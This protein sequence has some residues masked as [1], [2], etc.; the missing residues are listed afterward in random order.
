MVFIL[1]LCVA[2]VS[3]FGQGHIMESIEANPPD[4]LLF[5]TTFND[6]SARDWSDGGNNGTITT[7]TFSPGAHGGAFEFNGSSDYIGLGNSSRLNPR[8][9]ITFCI[10]AESPVVS[11]A[12]ARWVLGRDDNALGRSYA[13]GKATGKHELQISGG[14]TINRQGTAMVND[15]WYHYAAVGSAA[16]GWD[17]YLDGAHNGS[18][19][20]SVPNATTGATTIGKRTLNVS[21]L[22]WQGQIAEVLMFDRVLSAIELLYWVEKGLSQ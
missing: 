17:T 7:P 18:A 1:L 14:G 21:Q 4:G 22:W 9:N 6:G 20:W 11:V 15:T 5:G 2:V 12:G 10:W 19:G 3:A 13:F 8:V 16:T